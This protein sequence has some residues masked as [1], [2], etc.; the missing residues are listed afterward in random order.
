LI[1]AV[2]AGAL[3]AA[4]AHA[5]L[6]SDPLTQKAVFEAVGLPRACEIT[7]GSPEVVIAVV[8]S[9]VEAS[10]PDLAG[11]VL[12]VKQPMRQYLPM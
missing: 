6:P 10:H 8:D 4:V 12:I 2:L 11:A 1:T 7:T 3:A 9:G 5:A